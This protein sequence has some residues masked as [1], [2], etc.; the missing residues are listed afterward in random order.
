[1]GSGDGVQFSFIEAPREMRNMIMP[2]TVF[3]S[4]AREDAASAL[5]LYSDLREFGLQ[6]WLDQE[7]LLPGQNWRV[8]VTRAIEDSRYFIAV[9]SS[10]SVNRRGFVNK[11]IVEAL[12]ILDT[13]PEA[14]V[15]L[16]PAR[17]DECQP[18]HTKLRSLNW[19]D[20]FP[21]WQAG[22]AKILHAIKAGVPRSRSLGSDGAELNIDDIIVKTGKNHI[23]LDVRLRNAGKS[24]VNITRADLHVLERLPYAGAYK[25]SA[26]YD[27]LLEGDHNITAVAHALKP[28]EVDR[29][30]IR[31]GFTS[32][33]TSCGYTAELILHYNSDRRVSS[34]PF[35][36]ESVFS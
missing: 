10:R 21:D 16:I 25:A 28:H 18:S 9:I 11:E 36:F 8:A 22:I 13:F 32:Y 19:V 33:N 27:L 34:R 6:P 31:V 1:M 35:T 17:L 15:Y 30:D 4:Y 29:F 26:S 23:K 20:M 12:E 2:E 7:D 24:L 5:R 14:D 3:I